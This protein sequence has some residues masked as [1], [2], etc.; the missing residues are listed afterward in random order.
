MPLIRLQPLPVVVLPQLSQE[1]QALL[2]KTGECLYVAYGVPS[3]VDQVSYPLSVALDQ[4]NLCL[5][6]ALVQ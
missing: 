3:K 1:L 5:L 4:T 2:R 6:I